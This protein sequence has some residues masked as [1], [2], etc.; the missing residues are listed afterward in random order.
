MRQLL[1]IFVLFFFL[2]LQTR[3]QA[4]FGR[5][6]TDKAIGS[7]PPITVATPSIIRLPFDSSIAYVT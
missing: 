5:I 4:L 2:S 1:R 3:W 6:E 7:V